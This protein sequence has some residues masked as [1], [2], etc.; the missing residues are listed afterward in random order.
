[1]EAKVGLQLVSVDDEVNGFWDCFSLG[2]YGRRGDM[3]DHKCLR[4]ALASYILRVWKDKPIRDIL[5]GSHLNF[6]HR[7]QKTIL[8]HSYLSLLSDPSLPVIQQKR[9]RECLEVLC[10]AL[11]L[12]CRLS[13]LSLDRDEYVHCEDVGDTTSP[14]RVFVALNGPKFFGFSKAVTQPSHPINNSTTSSN[15]SNK[16]TTTHDIHPI[17]SS[18]SPTPTLRPQI[19]ISTS[20]V[21]AEDDCPGWGVPPLENSDEYLRSSWPETEA[22][23]R[24]LSLYNGILTDAQLLQRVNWTHRVS[25]KNLNLLCFI[26]MCRDCIRRSRCRRRKDNALCRTRT[27]L[28]LK[29]FVRFAVS[30]VCEPNSRRPNG[31]SR[32]SAMATFRGLATIALQRRMLKICSTST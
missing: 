18:P 27:K 12:R 9:P 30:I 16:H 14:I 1:M 15:S 6:V 28:E 32:S 24:S 17:T 25:I 10:T 4:G 2:F 3:N 19:H 31:T 29:R 13:V 11:M 26:H 7:A 5:T 22:V 8:L 21:P 23:L 20:S